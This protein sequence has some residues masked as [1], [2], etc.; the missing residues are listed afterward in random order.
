MKKNVS[1]FTYWV[2]VIVFGVVFGTG[3]QIARAW[4]EPILPPPSGNISG[5]L[6]TS[7]TGQEKK[8]NLVISTLNT[9]TNGLIVAYG[10]V[11]I[12]TLNPQAKLDVNGKAISH[13]TIDTDP[14]N[15]LVTKDYVDAQMGGGSGITGG[16]V[17]FIS[18]DDGKLYV[19]ERWGNGCSQGGGK[20]D[21]KKD[22][23]Y[24][25]R[26]VTTAGYEC[27]NAGALGEQRICICIKKSS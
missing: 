7:A 22:W 9:I 25:C 6:T 20:V 14:G 11:G 8:G 21:M 27:G 26:I 18:N 24:P 15:T 12:G 1:S 17:A 2:S 10:K 5:P 19:P 4:T 16:C 13:S 23:Y 3:L